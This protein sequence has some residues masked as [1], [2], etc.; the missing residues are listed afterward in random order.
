MESLI[1]RARWN[2]ALLAL[3]FL[4]SGIRASEEGSVVFMLLAMAAAG[5]TVMDVFKFSEALD[6]LK[7]SEKEHEDEQG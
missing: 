1:R 2:S 4:S 5:F 6:I 3:L 7:K